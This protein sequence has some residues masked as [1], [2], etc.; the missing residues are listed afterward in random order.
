ME[1]RATE[2]QGNVV[3]PGVARG[4]ALAFCRDERSA[5]LRRR[6]EEAGRP[7]DASP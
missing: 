3:S 2:L 6:A 1:A 7:E 4:P 5:A